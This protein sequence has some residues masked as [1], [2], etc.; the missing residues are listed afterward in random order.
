MPYCP[1]CKAEYREGFKI[2]VDCKVPLVSELADDTVVDQRETESERKL[3]DFARLFERGEQA[4]DAEDFRKALDQLNKASLLNPDNV[5]VWNLLGLTYQALGHD[6]EAWRSFKFAL[7]A[8]PDDTHALWYAAQFL[9]EREDYPLALSFISR[10]IELE[11]DANELKEAESLREDIK[12][13]LQDIDVYRDAA[14]SIDGYD[15]DEADEEVPA[16]KFTILDENDEELDGEDD[17]DDEPV[18]LTEESDFLADLQLQLTDRN[19]KC[20]FCGAAIPTDAPHCF[21]CKEPHLY[22]PL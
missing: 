2:C 18:E 11:T 21:N 12:Y 5:E 22:K 13:H 20:T 9:H 6:R 15:E 3:R 7:R 1:K 19:S 14:T 4:L 17:F 10:Y 16:D 8:D